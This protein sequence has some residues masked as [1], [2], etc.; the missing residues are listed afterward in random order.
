VA[1]VLDNARKPEEWTVIDRKAFFDGIR[2][3]LFLGT[4]TQAQ[5]S[6]IDAILDEWEARKLKDLRWL[7][8][9]LATT[10]HET[11]ATMQPV[12]EAY[13]LSE[14]WRRRNLRYYPWYGRGYV[15]LT[16]EE[17]YRK[18]GRLLGV[19]LLGNL[20]LAM[21]PHIAAAIMFEGML[22]AAS[23]FGDFTGKCLEMYFN[24]TTDDPVGARRIINGTDKA[25]L[26]AGYHRGFLTD[27]KN[28]SFCQRA[29]A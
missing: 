7:A 19:D 9:M 24:D 8:Y 11:N 16:W 2:P 23:G 29:S 13:W 15:Q 4:L 3:D 1:A 28:A 27:L 5:V 22:M 6:G 10:Y 20:D 21:D 18:M 25:E 12:R 14:D 17:N 26:I